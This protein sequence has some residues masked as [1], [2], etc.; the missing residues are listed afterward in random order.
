MVKIHH[1]FMLIQSNSEPCYRTADLGLSA[2]ISLNVPLDAIDRTDPRRAQFLFVRTDELDQ[3]VAAYY[4][5]ELTVEPQEYFA[6][7]KAM[8]ARLYENG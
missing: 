5:R 2:L 7:I 3:I 6:G 8:K 1:L 4:R